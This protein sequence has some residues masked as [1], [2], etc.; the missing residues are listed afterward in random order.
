ML[1]ESVT[2]SVEVGSFVIV[3][4]DRGEDLGVVVLIAPRDS[5][6][7]IALNNANSAVTKAGEGELKKILRIASLQERAELTEKAKD[8]MEILKVRNDAQNFPYMCTRFQFSIQLI[9][10]YLPRSVAN[11]HLRN[12]ICQFI[13]SMQNTNST[14][15]NWSFTTLRQGK[16]IK[17]TQGVVLTM[18]LIVERESTSFGYL[19]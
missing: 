1:G 12:T 8:E 15:T 14:D 11:G 5:P 2:Q 16:Q 18:F 7:A 13:W 17:A 19:N 9:L 10:F 3:E 4:A 6:L